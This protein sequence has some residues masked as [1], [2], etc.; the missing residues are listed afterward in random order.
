MSSEPAATPPD[1]PATVPDPPASPPDPT[2]SPLPLIE[3]S[4]GTLVST[5]VS[6][7]SV[8]VPGSGG[9]RRFFR[10][11]VIAPIVLVIA[12]SVWW[13]GFR[14]DAG[15]SI[16][17][18]ATTQTVAT[19]TR[20]SMTQS[21][22]SEGTVAAARTDDL[23]FSSSGTV[24]AVNVKA[25]DVVT[26]GEVLATID[27]AQLQSGVSSAESTLADAE[28]KLADDQSSGASDAQIAADE[29]SVTSANDSL[30]NAQQALAG[31]SLVATFDGTVSV[32]NVTVGDKLASGGTGGTGTTGSAS[33]SGRSSASIGSSTSGFGPAASSS[34]SSSSSSPQIQVVSK[35][36]YSVSLSVSSNDIAGV[37]VG[38]PVTVTL[39]TSSA[40][41][42]GFGGFGG[43]FGGRFGGDAE[44][45][46]P[47]RREHRL[48]RHRN[49]G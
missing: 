39:S 8:D 22:S 33:G 42:G 17:A 45:G 13:F 6:V 9:I 12:F 31:A 21:V 41:T 20:G 15:S 3:A 47:R 7:P 25:G 38:Q 4:D 11:R 27:S 16:P 2:A 30:T 34:S 43:R 36:G 46:T 37:V 32:V 19:V 29:T 5:G 44:E 24:T 48:G 14:S 1:P 10:P 23:S 35:G 18:A 40:A 49:V 28:A 26:A